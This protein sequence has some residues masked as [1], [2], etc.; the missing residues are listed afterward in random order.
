MPKGALLQI[1]SSSPPLVKLQSTTR[2]VTVLEHN[3]ADPLEGVKSIS[4]NQVCDLSACADNNN[5]LTILV[6]N[7]RNPLSSQ[8]IDTSSLKY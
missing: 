6:S 3:S 5:G 4:L 7:F 8:P 1:S 2:T